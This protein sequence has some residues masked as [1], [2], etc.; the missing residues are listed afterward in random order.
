MAWR[1]RGPKV[2]VDAHV[3]SFGNITTGG[4]GK[5]PAVIE[6]VQHEIASKR[7]VAVVTRG[8]G[9]APVKEP[10]VVDSSMGQAE[11][12]RLVGDEPA[13][14]RHYAPECILIKAARRADGARLA[15]EAFGCDVII[16]DDA[17]QHVELERN[18]N[19]CL[20]DAANPFGNGHLVPRGIL[21]EPLSALHRAT[22]IIVTRCD[23]AVNLPA[24]RA[25][26]SASVP[27]LPIRE[28]IHAV[29]HL[30]NL[31]SGERVDDAVLK[32]TTV[33]ALSAI[34]HPEAFL[35]TLTAQG[36]NI[37]TVFSL[38]DHA[39]IPA[40]L[41]QSP[42][43]IVTTEKDAMRIIDPPDNLYALSIALRD[44]KES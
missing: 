12:A 25:Q 1:L 34:G 42:G 3:I 32:N 27:D 4:T 17:Y 22:G 24:L 37:G 36:I 2:A 11:V 35:K 44:W 29:T 13:L 30:W 28:T 39:D 16:L 9:S 23:Q 38:R 40:A 21:R 8:Y 18:E 41:L 6:R 31:R 14:I 5:T 20:I 19:L 26:L 7:S 15:V 10:F 43:P 33:T